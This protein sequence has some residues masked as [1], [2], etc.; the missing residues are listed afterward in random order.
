MKLNIA[1]VF[2][3]I[4]AI[5]G[6]VSLTSELHPVLT[7]E[8]QPQQTLREVP[9]PEVTAD[10]SLL[11]RSTTPKAPIAVGTEMIAIVVGITGLAWK[12]NKNSN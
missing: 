9:Q 11:G 12:R 4:I 6:V 2:L 8:S 7:S 1:F 3:A 10:M 5:G